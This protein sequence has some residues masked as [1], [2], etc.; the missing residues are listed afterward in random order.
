MESFNKFN[1]L[2]NFQT[3]FGQKWFNQW[4]TPIIPF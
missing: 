3:A 1:N 4:E 2:K